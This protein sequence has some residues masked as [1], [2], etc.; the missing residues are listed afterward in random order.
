MGGPFAGYAESTSFSLW[1]CSAYTPVECAFFAVVSGEDRV[2]LRWTMDALAG[3]RGFHVYRALHEN[4][5][6]E[7]ANQ[8]LLPALSPGTY[9]DRTVWPGTQFW[10]ELRAQMSNGSEQTVTRE[11]VTV[12][13]QGELGNRLFAVS[14]NPFR[15]DA[16]LHHDISSPR[17]ARLVIYDVNGRMVRT[18]KSGYPRPGRYVAVWDGTSD[19]GRRVASGVYFCSLEAGGSRDRRAIVLLK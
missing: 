8:S 9:E 6:F 18:L 2:T 19:S 16:H 4:G 12:R 5:P 11:P 14:P 17:G 15:D 1:G 13:T 7:R 3:I 10:Y